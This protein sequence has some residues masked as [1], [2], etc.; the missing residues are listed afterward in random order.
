M[1]SKDEDSAFR[2]IMESLEADVSAVERK[3]DNEKKA[4]TI[5]YVLALV[6]GFILLI[7][8]VAFNFPPVAFVGFPLMFAGAYLLSKSFNI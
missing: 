3:I 6:F 8:S 1:I 7:S 5:L 2:S 4:K